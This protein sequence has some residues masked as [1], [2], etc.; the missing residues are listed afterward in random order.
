MYHKLLTRSARDLQG[1][2][3]VDFEGRG[4]TRIYLTFDSLLA[5]ES[6]KSERGRVNFLIKK[7]N[8][9]VLSFTVETGR[10]R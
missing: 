3:Y 2:F 8:L 4:Y 9:K 10:D 5:S 6:Q 1:N 7:P